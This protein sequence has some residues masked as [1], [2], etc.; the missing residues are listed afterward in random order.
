MELKQAVKQLALANNLDYVGMAAV[1]SLQGEPAGRKPT[2]YL[3]G[4]QT[5][6]SLGIKLSLGVQL[7]NKL[8]HRLG[9]RYKIFPYLWHGFNL[10]SWHFLDRTALLVS[11]LLEKSGYIAVPVMSGS[12]FDIQSNL[13]E[14]SNNHTAVAA[15]LGD[16]GW[17]GLVLTLDVGPR[18]RFGS[19]IT[20]AKL[21][22]DRMYNGPKLC[23][24]DKCKKMGQ[25]EPICR[26]VCPTKA[27]GT[28]S[29]EVILGDKHFE[30]ARLDRFR[31]M[32]GSMGLTKE[33]F[34]S[35]D[36]PM[37]ENVSVED[38]FAALGRRESAQAAELMCIK[39]RGDYCGR[40]IME[41]P[42]GASKMVDERFL[43]I[44]S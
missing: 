25:G 43:N 40:C 34:Q 38:V 19:V 12:N 8:A 36:I 27:L 14:F 7:S 21:D 11:R 41:C 44:H 23:D 30:V 33:T 32:W 9:Q 4:A 3:P 15:G 42:V 37:P 22:P 39:D 16:L 28:D 13:M 17:S 6:I 2:N 1:D 20:T 10:P 31:C 18:V 5:V 35:Q 29:A 26:K 24:L